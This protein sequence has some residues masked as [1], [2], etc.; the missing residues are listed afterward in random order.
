MNSITR[1]IGMTGVLLALVA[2]PT[3]GADTMPVDS[4]PITSQHSPNATLDPW[5]QHVLERSS[6]V[7]EPVDSRSILSRSITPST[8]GSTVKAAQA[9]SPSSGFGWTDAGIGSAATL[10][11]LMLIV[12]TASVVRHTRQPG[13]D[14]AGT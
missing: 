3:A 11:F 8:S 7:A 14:L 5:F 13:G 1:T 6:S 4:R 2:V 10:I 9:A 12:L